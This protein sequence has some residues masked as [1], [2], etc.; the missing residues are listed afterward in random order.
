MG[1]RLVKLFKRLLC[2]H[3]Y[4]D[5]LHKHPGS[6]MGGPRSEPTVQDEKRRTLPVTV[7]LYGHCLFLCEDE[8]RLSSLYNVVL[9]C[10]APRNTT[11]NVAK[12]KKDGLKYVLYYRD[13]R[14]DPTYQHPSFKGRVD[15]TDREL[16]D[17]DVSL[18]LKNVTIS[19]RGTY[20]CRVALHHHGL[21][22]SGYL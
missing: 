2:S 3:L 1:L 17:G 15:L 5:Q 13:G 10:E 8:T 7:Q 22:G 11:I 16:K 12:W 21:H 14:S 18:V 19:D 9:K 4:R 20:E 6:W